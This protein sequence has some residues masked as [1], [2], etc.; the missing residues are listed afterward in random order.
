MEIVNKTLPPTTHT[1]MFTLYFVDILQETKSVQ[2][3]LCTILPMYTVQTHPEY[4][5]IKLSFCYTLLTF[6]TLAD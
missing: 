5:F 1:P 2:Y 4:F 3:S 6:F